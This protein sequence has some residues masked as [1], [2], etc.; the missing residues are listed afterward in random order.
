V[1]MNLGQNERVRDFLY[2]HPVSPYL[3]KSLEAV[4]LQTW[5][6][7]R[8]IYA[9]GRVSDDFRGRFLRPER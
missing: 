7:G 2:K 8:K 5:V 6:R 3:G 9:D 1:L 4:V